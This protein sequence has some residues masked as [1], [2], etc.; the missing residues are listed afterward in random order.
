MLRHDTTLRQ[1]SFR[2]GAS[3]SPICECGTEE[4]SVQH[5]L[6]Q[7]QN[8]TA[9]RSELFNNTEDCLGEKSISEVRECFLLSPSLQD[10][11]TKSD[12]FFIKEALFEY[13]SK[14][15]RQM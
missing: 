1:D 8:Y 15:K 5:F 14:S 10:N 12:M 11:I 7:C 6:L 9:I 4:E 2:T 3:L 13:I